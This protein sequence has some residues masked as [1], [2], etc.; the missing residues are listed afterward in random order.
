MERFAYLAHHRMLPPRVE[1]D[2][3]GDIR[4]VDASPG[5]V[6]EPHEAACRCCDV[7]GVVPVMHAYRHV[8]NELFGVSHVPTVGRPGEINE[9]S[10]AA[11]RSNAHAPEGINSGPGQYE[12][13]HHL[14]LRGHN[15]A[16]LARGPLLLLGL[17]SRQYTKL[18]DYRTA[19]AAALTAAAAAGV[20]VSDDA[21]AAEAKRRAV[22]AEQRNHRKHVDLSDAVYKAF[23][24]Q[25][26]MAALRHALAA[27]GDESVPLAERLCRFNVAV[28]AS[29]EARAAY[30]AS[31]TFVSNAIAS[32]V[33]VTQLQA[34]EQLVAS[35]TSGSPA[36]VLSAVATASADNMLTLLLTDLHDRQRRLNN[37]LRKDAQAA[38]ADGQATTN[39]VDMVRRTV[40]EMAAAFQRLALLQQLSADA[41]VRGFKVP[42]RLQYAT[43]ALPTRVGA[44]AITAGNA[45]LDAVLTA[46]NLRVGTEYEIDFLLK[47][48]QRGVSSAVAV[49]AAL[50][51]QLDAATAHVD[52]GVPDIVGASGRSGLVLPGV[53]RS[54]ANGGRPLLFSTAALAVTVPGLALFAHGLAHETYTGLL[55]AR[56]QLARWQRL[57]DALALLPP[58]RG[59]SGVAVQLDRRG[60]SNFTRFGGALLRGRCSPA[61]WA[62]RVLDPG[63]APPPAAAAVDGDGASGGGDGSDGDG[64]DDLEL[65]ELREEEVDEEE[66]VRHGDATGLDEDTEEQAAV[67]ADA[68]CSEGDVD[69]RLAALLAAAGAGAD[70]SSS[71]G[72]GAAEDGEDDDGDGC[73]CDMHGSEPNGAA[74][75]AAAAAAAAAAPAAAELDAAAAPAADGVVAAA[76][77]GA[78]DASVLAEGDDEGGL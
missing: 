28:A 4:V 75:D 49:V 69:G 77:A 36:A 11:V 7:Q 8:C 54:H 67:P 32:G 71:D 47:D 1:I 42:E 41:A 56:E 31:S 73:C 44:V 63:S 2:V 40:E 61:S 27:A 64:S 68:S 66:A 3:D 22:Q 65:A 33:A 23:A 53:G 13:L 26:R 20:D 57:R 21:L 35:Q 39:R 9:Q 78:A 19:E 12:T 52:A 10:F 46:H 18:R 37:L 70:D 17:L 24:Q 48:V 6:D 76:L 50:E 43:V 5:A 34:V 72:D 14:T 62:A 29:S 45:T 15:V 30:A 60:C 58:H 51:A 55:Q 74:A 38:V 25:A 59:G 16:R